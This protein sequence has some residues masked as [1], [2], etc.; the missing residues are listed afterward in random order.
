MA[1]VWTKVCLYANPSLEHNSC[2]SVS[3]YRRRRSCR[4]KAPTKV[5]ILESHFFSRHRLP[6]IL[7][8]DTMLPTSLPNSAY[9]SW[10]IAFLLGVAVLYYYTTKTDIP[11]I[12][13]IPEIPGALPMFSISLLESP[14]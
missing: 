12:R 4:D 10:I 6:P 14:S 8:L 9:Y 13:G 1:R 11:K 2:P 3:A 5:T 7:T